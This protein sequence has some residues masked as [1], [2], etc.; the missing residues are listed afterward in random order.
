MTF[1]F[2]CKLTL[3]SIFTYMIFKQELLKELVVCAPGLPMGLDLKFLDELASD[4]EQ[5]DTNEVCNHNSL[6]IWL[7]ALTGII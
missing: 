4:D 5:H 6:R 3:D 2:P 1:V 7:K